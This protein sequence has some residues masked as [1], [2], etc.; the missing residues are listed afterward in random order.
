MTHVLRAWRDSRMIR[1]SVLIAL[2]LA[3]LTR[4]TRSDV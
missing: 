2:H 1:V 3:G 4:R